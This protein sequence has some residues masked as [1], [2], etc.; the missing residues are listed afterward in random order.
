MASTLQ[1]YRLKPEDENK[2]IHPHKT[3]RTVPIGHRPSSV[4]P[5]WNEVPLSWQPETQPQVVPDFP[6]GGARV[7][8]VRRA[9]APWT[10]A[11]FLLLLQVEALNSVASS[12]GIPWKSAMLPRKARG[13]AI[14]QMWFKENGHV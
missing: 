3:L 1:G 8:I 10:P 2:F 5:G 7:P 4:T 12:L 14:G 9:R 13:G 11:L 6:L